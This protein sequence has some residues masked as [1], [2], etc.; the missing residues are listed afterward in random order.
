[1]SGGVLAINSGTDTPSALRVCRRITWLLALVLL[2]VVGSERVRAEE[3][4]EPALPQLPAK[5]R[6]QLEADHLRREIALEKLRRELEALQGT[7]E[8]DVGRRIERLGALRRLLEVDSEVR[9]L[10][11]D[12]PEMAA[13]YDRIVSAS[14]PRAAAVPQGPCACLESARVHWLGEGDQAGQV[15]VYLDGLYHDV[16]AG[17]EIGGSRCSVQQVMVD[18]VTLECGGE[19]SARSLHNPVGGI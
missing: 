2:P 16:Q 14:A 18:G 1:M 12:S 9:E 8:G 3:S 7:E 4:A 11:E 13:E 19:T 6:A 17:E 10:L 5:I 15:I